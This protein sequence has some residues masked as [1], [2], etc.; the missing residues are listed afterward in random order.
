M[1]TLKIDRSFVA[2]MDGNDKCREIVRTILSLA[3]ALGLDVVAEGTETAAQV[4]Y[5][6]GL[7]CRFGQGYFFSGPVRI[8]ELPALLRSGAPELDAVPSAWGAPLDR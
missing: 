8:E 7:D 1:D 6:E 5:L 4:D 3:R 2:G